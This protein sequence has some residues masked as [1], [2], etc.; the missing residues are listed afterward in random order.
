[1]ETNGFLS[2]EPGVGPGD[3]GL[4]HRLTVTFSAEDPD[5]ARAHSLSLSRLCDVPR[6]QGMAVSLLAAFG[7]QLRMVVAPHLLP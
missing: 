4:P 7:I 3:S 1:M 6:Q 5:T 2:A